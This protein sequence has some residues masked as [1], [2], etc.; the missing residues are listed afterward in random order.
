[1]VAFLLNEDMEASF[2][3]NIH[4]ACVNAKNKASKKLVQDSA[5]AKKVLSS[6]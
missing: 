2:R 1:V 5:L 4:K 6:L 3:F